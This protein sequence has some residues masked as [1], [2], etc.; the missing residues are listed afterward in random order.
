VPIRPKFACYFEG[1]QYHS[2]G[3]QLGRTLTR[4]SETQGEKAYT[5]GD[6]SSRSLSNQSG[7]RASSLK[8]ET[9]SKYSSQP[10]HSL[11][12]KFNHLLLNHSQVF[13]DLAI[14]G[15]TRNTDVPLSATSSSPQRTTPSIVRQGSASR[16]SVF[17]RFLGIGTQLPE[18][19]TLPKKGL[20][21]DANVRDGSIQS[22]GYS[23]KSESKG[24]LNSGQDLA[25]VPPPRPSQDNFVSNIRTRNQK[26]NYDELDTSISSV[27]KNNP[28][29]EIANNQQDSLFTGRRIFNSGRLVSQVVF[30]V[31]N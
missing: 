4:Y 30:E 13:T 19:L 10:Q 14:N 7:S 21:I 3:N 27:S 15:H 8:V 17:D 9:P 23:S 1:L 12:T 28:P 31:Q 25:H 20:P 26:R 5:S 16:R 29:S 2:L 18:T 22:F 6:P 24:V 11:V